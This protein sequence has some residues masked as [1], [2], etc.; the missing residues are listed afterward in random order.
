MSTFP[1]Q[2]VPVEPKQVSHPIP[3]ETK[4]PVETKQPS[5]ADALRKVEAADLAVKDANV[6]L[7]A[8]LTV[9][10]GAYN[11]AA[12]ARVR[13]SAVKADEQRKQSQEKQKKALDK[14]V[15]AAHDHEKDVP[16]KKAA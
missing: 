12:E 6:A 5:Y 4:L 10:A 2:V 1:T 3:V 15:A 7:K 11:D 9:Q 8:A 14:A 16:A 13:E